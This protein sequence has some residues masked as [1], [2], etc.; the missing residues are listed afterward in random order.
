MTTGT[1]ALGGQPSGARTAEGAALLGRLER[2]PLT[3]FHL[4]IAS[5]LGL[6]T[7]FDA[8]D[9]VVI[10]VALTAILGSFGASV[11]TAGLLIAAGSL[12]QIVGATG[13]GYAS[14]RFGRRIAFIASSLLF[15]LLS[16]GAAFAWSI[17]SLLVLRLIQG[18]G[19]GA[20]VPVAAAMFNEFARARSRGRIALAYGSLFVWGGLAAS[21]T[22]GVLL[23]V[24]PP[25]D[26]WRYLFAIGTVPALAA[27]W[28]CLRLPESPRHLVRHG[29]LATARA[30]VE[31]M[32]ASRWVSGR[33]ETADDGAAVPVAPLVGGHAAP[34][35]A[36]AFPVGVDCVVVATDAQDGRLGLHA[37]AVAFSVNVESASGRWETEGRGPAPGRRRGNCWIK[38][39][40][41]PDR[42][43]QAAGLCRS[44]RSSSGHPPPRPTHLGIRLAA[45]PRRTARQR[46][47]AQPARRGGFSRA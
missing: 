40:G 9:T 11:E 7:F 26:A 13:L 47:A 12:G 3:R 10:S 22:A 35:V 16:L 32:E 42:Q 44:A 39:A 8:F 43:E 14:E 18:L 41:V 19:L 28:A 34:L 20:E 33:E 6:A 2:L 23:A 29:D 15:G 21:L 45:T 25:Q 36:R 38:L 31:Q 46:R 24:F 17:P 4:R 5:I 37:A 27:L 30:V 1:G